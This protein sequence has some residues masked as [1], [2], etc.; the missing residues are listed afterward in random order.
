MANIEFEETKKKLHL[1][2][3]DPGRKKL[4]A[5]DKVF[6]T[7]S[8]KFGTINIGKSSLEAMNMG[9]AW[10]K[11]AFDSTNQII[12]WK[13]RHEL[14]N[15]QIEESGWRFC[16]PDAV[17]GQATIS[18]RRIMDTMPG[19]KQDSYKALEV[20]KYRDTSLIGDNDDTNF[21]FYIQIQDFTE[22]ERVQD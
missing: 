13:V 18:V 4:V 7:A 6:V 21:W 2:L 8:R 20:K 11:L 19:L 10:Y 16:K 9:N 12:A 5:A 3:V 22:P 14:L 17:A 1:T 15:N